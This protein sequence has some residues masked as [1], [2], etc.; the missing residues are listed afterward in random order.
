MKRIN[1][2]KKLFNVLPTTDLAQLKSTYKSLIKEWHPDKF[3]ESHPLHEE[4]KL[5]GAEIIDGYHFLVSIA[6]ETKEAKM[7]QYLQT[8]ETGIS[9]YKHKGQVLDLTFNDGAS[10]EYFGISSAGFQ[11]FINADKQFRFAKRNIFHSYLYR[12]TKKSAEVEVS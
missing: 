3:Q 8:I 6:N 9:D 11:K 2:Y 1:Q 10:Y 12:Q 7:S 4:A 5:K